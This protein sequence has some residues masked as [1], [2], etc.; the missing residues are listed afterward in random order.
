MMAGPKVEQRLAAILAADVAGYSR[1]MGADERATITT[2]SEFR[3]VFREEIEANRGRIVDM[4]GDS[5]LAIFN[6]AI[7]AVSAAA[8]AQSELA[9]RNEGL[10]EDRRMLFRVGV[11]LGDI[12]EAEDGRVYG[13]GVNVA[14]RLEALASP[15]GVNVSGSVFDSVRSKVGAS[16]EFLGEHEVKNIAEP[17]RTYR[18]LEPGSKSRAR[19]RN[20]HKLISVAAVAA[21]AI[22]VAISWWFTRDASEPRM[23]TAEGTPTDDPTLAMPTGPSIAVL[24]FANLS[25]DPEQD[26]FADGIAGDILTQLSRVPRLKVISRGSSFRFRDK[27]LDAR[28]IAKELG[29]EFLVLGSV[30]RAADR[31]RVTAELLKGD[32]GEQLW[33]DSYDRDLAVTDLFAVQDEITQSIVATVA[34]E[35]GIL[36]QY[37]RRQR[38]ENRNVTLGS[39]ECV[40]LGYAYFEAT[41]PENHARARDCLEQAVKEDPDYGDAWGWLA[42]IYAH[43]HANGFNTRP[44]SLERALQAGNKGVTADPDSQLAWEGKAAAHFFRHERKAFILAAEKAV[45][46]NPN[47]VSTIA[48][49]GWYYATWGMRDEGIPLLKKAIRLSPHP[50]FWYHQPLFMQAFLEHDY[51]AALIHARN[52][53]LPGYFFSNMQLA[54]AYAE[55]GEKDLAAEEVNTI[56]SLKP[57]AAETFRGFLRFFNVPEPEIEQLAKSLR[58]AGLSIPDEPVPTE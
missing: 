32:S 30:Q 39:Y 4:A 22:I 25:G 27:A 44:E 24:P 16:F 8:A 31:I 54:A 1:L 10:P 9:K 46:L 37:S 14:A 48:N 57:D 51:E 7:G 28:E 41:L 58:K 52:A 17:V 43:E 29:V 26:F 45:E 50:T 53:N 55:L 18:I 34:D 49:M 47:D 40:L 3:D 13:D 19:Q 38:A 21:F 56:L 12:Q 15:G 35:Y 20:F 5:V 33:S 2:L 11:N 42:I 23:E 36:S 6:S